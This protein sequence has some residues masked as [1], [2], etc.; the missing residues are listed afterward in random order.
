MR[1]ELPSGL[2]IQCSP[3]F[4]W[5]KRNCDLRIVCESAFHPRHVTSKLCLDLLDTV[6]PDLDCRLFLDVGCGSGI[7]ALAAL[8]LG[9][10]TAVGVDIDPKAIRTSRKNALAN[11]LSERCHWIVGTSATVRGQ[12][13]CVA[14]NLP[15]AVLMRH[16]PELAS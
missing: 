1:L 10:S 7:L 8:R 11:G 9:A 15:Y 16:M 14:A 6:L 13:D 2:V 3:V 12:F 5:E 4:P